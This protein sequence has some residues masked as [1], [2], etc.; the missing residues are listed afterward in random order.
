MDFWWFLFG[1]SLLVPVLMIVLGRWMQ[2]HCPA[3]INR[4]VGHRTKRSMKNPD[5]WRF[6]HEYCGRLWWKWGWRMLLPSVLVLLP[7]M[8]R[9]EDAAG[10]ACGL[11][12][13]VQSLLLLFSIILTEKALKRSFPE[14]ETDR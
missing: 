8:H 14:T 5:T 3:R 4:V 1:C 2:K 9:S 7:F 12:V 11:L 10:T 6:A 13:T